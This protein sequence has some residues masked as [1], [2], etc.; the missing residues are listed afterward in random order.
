MDPLSNPKFKEFC[1]RH[2]NAP[3]NRCLWHTESCPNSAIRAHS[4]QNSGALDLIAE[5]GH[6]VM[7]HYTIKDESLQISFQKVGRNRATTFT[8]L[9]SDHDSELFRPIDTQEF[10]PTD[11]EHLFLIAYRS[12]LKEFHAAL[13]SGSMVQGIF[14]KGVELGALPEDGAAMMAATM[15]LLGA[16]KFYPFVKFFHHH[17]AA[18]RFSDIRHQVL[19]LNA[20]NKAVAATGVFLPV[21]AES[22]YDPDDP[23]LLVFNLFPTQSGVHVQFSWRATDDVLMRRVISPIATA[24]GE[25]Q[26]YL[27]S[28]FILKY[29]ETFALSP[30]LHASFEDARIEAI[31][32]YFLANAC[33]ERA[34]WD[35]PLLYLFREG[36]RIMN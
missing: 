14:A 25:F 6:V 26:M 16:I 28:K 23:Q 36:S 7:V 9:C 1:F 22:Q 18:R 35:D 5:D 12:A 3:F 29:T 27:L 15:Q 24:T 17:F 2:Q 33:G 20:P 8:G 11:P 31:H 10:S 34:E 4:V 21:E 30:S 32:K 13:H 19:S